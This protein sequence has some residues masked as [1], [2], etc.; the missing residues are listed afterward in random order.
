MA[1]LR[2]ARPH[3]P[4]PIAAHT[5]QQTSYLALLAETMRLFEPAA[6]ARLL[7]SDSASPG[8]AAT[9]AAARDWLHAGGKRLRPFLAVAAYT[10]TRHGPDALAPDAPL[11]SLIPLPVRKIAVA[12]EALHKASL[13]HDDIED[14]DAFRY[15][16][17]TLHKT[18]GVGPAINVGD[19]LVGLGYKLIADERAAL[20]SDRTADILAR[21]AAAHVD[22]SRGQGAELLWHPKNGERLRVA[23]ALAIYALK[24]A[25]AFD[26]ALYCGLRAADAHHDAPTIHRFCV[27]IG[28]AYQLLNDLDD[29]RP[30]KHN[31]IVAGR[32]GLAGR[33]TVLRAFAL[34]TAGPALLAS[35]SND[36]VRMRALYEEHGVFAR[37]DRLIA[38]LRKRAIT[39]TG[40]LQNPPLK[41]FLLFI[42]RSLL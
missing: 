37:A 31:K 8:L 30:D 12:I 34:R 4:A 24:T 13:V 6:L 17:E 11:P 23:E 16:R 5:L 21:L 14:G 3:A 29:W 26:A 1:E 18:L 19:Y 27:A 15:G 39:L 42:V 25:P 33:P 7:P 22:L 36:I 2:S 41:D 40:E 9:S 20:G 32:D 10:I 35:A 28:Q 38:R